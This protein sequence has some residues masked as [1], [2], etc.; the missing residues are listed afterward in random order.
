MYA[1]QFLRFTCLPWRT[2]AHDHAIVIFVIYAKT[3]AGL[4]T[5]LV[6][7]AKGRAARGLLRAFSLQ[8]PLCGVGRPIKTSLI[9]KTA[10]SV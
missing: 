5:K 2:D 3:Q 9:P 10:S 1:T 8:N 6:A 7:E 4:K